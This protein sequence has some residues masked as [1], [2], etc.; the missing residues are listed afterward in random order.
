MGDSIK[1]FYFILFYCL[2]TIRFFNPVFIP[3][4]LLYYIYYAIFFVTILFVILNYKKS[5][6]NR[7]T[8]P[9]FLLLIALLI[10]CFSALYSWNQNLLDS[11]RGVLFFMS[12][13]LFFLLLVLKFRV[14]DV[15]KII[16]ILGVLFIIVYIITFVSYPR[17]IFGN[18][19]HWGD[20]RGF[21]RIITNGLGFLFLFSFY[22][23][24]RYLDKRE[25]RWLIIYLI[26]LICI[27]MTLTRTLI[28][29]SFI[30]SALYILRKSSYLTKILSIFIIGSSIYLI[31]QMSFFKFLTIETQKQSENWQNDIRVRSADFYLHHFSPN[32]FAKIFGNGIPSQNSGYENYV[33]RIKIRYGYYLSDIGYIGLYVKYGLLAVIALFIFF[34]RITITKIPEEYLYIKYFLYFVFIISII[35]ESVTSYAYIPSIVLATYILSSKD[36]TQSNSIEIT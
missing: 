27:V 33:N 15:E 3:R 12:Y 34:Y 11:M 26:T 20:E 18:I 36:L 16:I 9:V 10:S 31:S 28:S 5:Y 22:S 35:I 7:L 25:F 29:I 6:N 30:L 1:A 32:T 23:L 8:L 21:Q 4:N 2:A 13:I 24:S 19:D 14:Q 17:L